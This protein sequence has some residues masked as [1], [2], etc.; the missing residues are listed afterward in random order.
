MDSSL[1]SAN[2]RVAVVTGSSSGIG[3]E[4]SLI[5]AR[6]GFLT[7]A[8]MRNLNK[9]ENIKLIATKE[10]LP[11]RVKQLDVTDDMSVQNAVQ[12]ISS[13]T[14]RI[15][16]LV[17]NAGYGLNGAFEDLAIDEIIACDRKMWKMWQAFHG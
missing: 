11:I 17:N 8:T 6:N 14:G 3:Y 12:A 16:I 7:Y 1:S 4:T 10:N 13:E 5:L 9:G 15:D 2:H